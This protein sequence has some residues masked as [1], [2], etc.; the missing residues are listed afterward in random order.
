[1]LAQIPGLSSWIALGFFLVRCLEPIELLAR[2]AGTQLHDCSSCAGQP[3]PVLKSIAN[4]NLENP[5]AATA[6]KSVESTIVR[7]KK[8][9]R[10]LDGTAR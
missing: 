6:A 5:G 10:R 9:T 1:M 3:K 8:S 4:F 2:I 7:K